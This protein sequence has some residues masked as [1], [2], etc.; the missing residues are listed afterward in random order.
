MSKWFDADK[1]GLRQ[2]GER[3]I[4]R[5]GFGII[6]AELYQNVRDTEATICHMS[7]TK[8]NVRGKYELI[9]EDND[10]IGFSDLSHAYTLYAPSL[11]KADPEKAGRFNVGEKFVLAFCKEARIE[12]TKGTVIFDASGRSEWPRRKRPEGTLFMGLIDCNEERLEQFLKHMRRILVKPGLKLT[13]NDEIIAPRTP[14]V[15]FEET[16]ATE[17]ADDKGDLRLTRRKTQ[18]ELFEVLPGET[19][20]LFELG[21]PVVETGDRWHYSVK[22]KCP[23]NVDRDNVTPAYLRDLRVY[24]LNHVHQKIAPE[25]TTT[26]WVE[27]A[28]GDDKVSPHALRTFK[29]QRYGENAVAEDPFN[30][31]AN[32][33]ALTDG[34]T[35]IPTHGLSKG[36]RDNLK[37]NGLLISSSVAYPTVGKGAYSDDPNALP[38][39]V[40][41]ESE[42]TPG[43]KAIVEYTYGVAWRLLAK[44]IRIRLVKWTRREGATWAACYGTGHL[45]GAPFFDYNVGVLGK[46]WFGNGVTIS[47]DSLILHELAHDLCQNHADEQYYRALTLLGARLKAAALKE[48]EWFLRYVN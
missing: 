28:T 37:N 36:Q 30:R 7:L 4:E 20:T 13:V 40:I 10:P 9:C 5:R 31:D 15:I 17:I 2:I 26:P 46:G 29:E 16:L 25:D 41:P 19:A 34:R 11:K 18:V 6:G 3:L 44:A 12:T 1:E 23:L 48:S 38:I 45:L 21:I 43:M 14:S 8:T 32:A 42:W 33:A 39:E 24:V 22:Q 47:V 35:L 27:E